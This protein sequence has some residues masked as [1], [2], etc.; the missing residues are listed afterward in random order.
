MKKILIIGDSFVEFPN[1][2]WNLDHG[3]VKETW[4][5]LIFDNIK[6]YEIIVDGQSSRDIQTIIDKWII[7]LPKLSIDDILIVCI[8]TFYRTRLP[9]KKENW[10]NCEFGEYK[11][12][13]KFIGANSYKE[14]DTMVDSFNHSGFKLK[15]DLI[16]IYQV[17]NSTP[18]AITNHLDVINSLK[19][20]TPCYSYLFSWDNISHDD[21][22]I[23]DKKILVDNIGIWETLNDVYIKTN[24]TDGV[25][26][27]MHWSKEM[28]ELFYNYLINKKLKN[29]I[30]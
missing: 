24:W 29:Y 18:S 12:L 25:S 21:H 17:L 22:E 4:V 1:E 19:M 23:E 2:N 5:K 28:H 9:L 15:T 27:D 13:N 7:H 26:K 8:P 20:I 30:L 6:N 16:E 3:Y 14:G 11:F 10:I